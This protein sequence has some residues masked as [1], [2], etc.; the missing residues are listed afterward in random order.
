MSKHIYIL[1]AGCS[2]DSGV[3]LM[4]GFLQRS[5]DISRSG[6]AGKF[7]KEF[8]M[9]L[10]GRMALT[11][12]HS[13]SSSIDVHNLEAVFSAFEMA[14]LLGKLDGFSAE[15]LD[16][17]PDMYKG[18][19]GRTIETGQQFVREGST[20]KAPRS[21]DTF[22]NL[23]KQRLKNDI[24]IITFNYDVG[25]DYALHSKGVR[26]DYALPGSPPSDIKLLKLHGSIHWAADGTDI[27]ALDFGS[28]V[29]R[30]RYD[31]QPRNEAEPTTFEICSALGQ[32]LGTK[33][34]PVIV[35]PTWNKSDY[36]SAIA[37]VWR[38]AAR[39]LSTAEHIYVI[40]YSL[41]RT[42]QFF[43]LL[44]ALGTQSSSTILRRV[45]VVNPDVKA[46]KRVN[47]G[48]G[49]QTQGLFEYY[50]KDFDQC[51]HEVELRSRVFPA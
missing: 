3:P 17:F 49:T 16:Q 37:N 27:R 26:I 6:R 39:E 15:E 31:L 29:A 28:A 45:I 10:K 1:G 22:A 41:P 33:S 14:K 21:Y 47:S 48:L 46:G 35:P 43:H 7:S 8:E 40:G 4:N 25:L 23:I 2:V 51:L 38:A 24:S 50:E 19:I 5:E 42:D 30:G 36:H 18:V 11:N 32:P 34:Y 13:K 20:L 44:F 9:V 12:T